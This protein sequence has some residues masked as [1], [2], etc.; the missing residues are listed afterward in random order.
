MSKKKYDM[1]HDI[2]EIGPTEAKEILEHPEN[3]KTKNRTVRPHRVDQ[4][5]KAMTNDDWELNGE[6]IQ[7]AKSGRLL[8]GQHRLAA[9]IKSGKK[10]P[11]LVCRNLRDDAVIT[12]DVGSMRQVSD[13]LRMKGIAEG[14]AMAVA[15]SINLISKF[16]DGKYVESRGSFSALETL[17]FL[18][19]DKIV[20]SFL[21]DPRFTQQSLYVS[22]MPP[23]L[24]VGMYYLFRKIDAQAAD[25]FYDKLSSGAKLGQ[26]SPIL[27]LRTQLQ[28]MSAGTS[29]KGR[30]YRRPVL[31]YMTAAFTAFLHDKQVDGTFKFTEKSEIVLPRKK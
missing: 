20:L 7:I 12:I 10:V 21:K 4:W 19:K 16:K 11:F 2:E 22:L 30:L 24:W 6:T 29:R 1:E 8:N 17:Q 18:D 28:S 23:A 9:V 25:E 5:A 26:R 13:F 31:Y 3:K 27:Q 15:A 14:Y